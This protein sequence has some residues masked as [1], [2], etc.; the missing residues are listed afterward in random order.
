MARNKGGFKDENG[1]TQKQALFVKYFLVD[2]NATKAAFRAG[3]SEKTASKIGAENLSKPAIARQIGAEGQKRLD[4][5]QVDADWVLRRLVDEAEADLADLYHEDGGLKP[6]KEWPLIW[7]QGLVAGVESIQEYEY[8]EGE[9]IPAGVL[10]KIKLSDRIKRI[11]LAGK[12]IKVNAF[13]ERL[14]VS[15]RPMLVDLSGGKLTKQMSDK[16]CKDNDE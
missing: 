15:H 11:E 10:Q 13:A 9:K 3:Y 14:D 8:V 2:R 5:V 1:L 4:R 16:Y 6:I 12:H 7:R